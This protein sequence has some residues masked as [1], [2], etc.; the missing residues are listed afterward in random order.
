MSITLYE[1][2]FMIDFINFKNII[3][4]L[5]FKAANN[6]LTTCVYTFKFKPYNLQ[7][8]LKCVTVQFANFDIRNN[9]WFLCFNLV[10]FERNLILNNKGIQATITITQLRIQKLDS[11]DGIR[12]I[13]FSFNFLSIH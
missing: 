13:L 4:L 8:T 12:S 11:D 7:V 5:S 2:I 6:N 1:P 3:L 9:Y 10:G